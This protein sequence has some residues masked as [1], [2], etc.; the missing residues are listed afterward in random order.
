MGCFGGDKLEDSTPRPEFSNRRCRDV[1]C[2]IL[3]GA[4]T[5]GMIVLAVYAFAT[6]NCGGS[7]TVALCSCQPEAPGLTPAV[8]VRH[9]SARYERD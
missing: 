3:F 7:A 2:L 8:R 9:R 4:F 5:I 6:G 1:L